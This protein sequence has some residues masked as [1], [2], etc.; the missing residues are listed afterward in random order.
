[1]RALI[2]AL[3]PES[4]EKDGLVT[5]LN[6]QIEAL[7]ARHGIAAQT[8]TSDEPEA[9]IEVKQVL[10]RIAQEA[11]HNTVKHSRARRVD[12][13]LEAYDSWLVLQ[14]TVDGVGFDTDESF[15]GHLGLRSM[16]E[17]ALEVGG[18]LEVESSRGQ[19]TRIVVRVPSERLWPPSGGRCL[20]NLLPRDGGRPP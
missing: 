2:F 6:R 9:P 8:I 20:P 1:M 3:R 12:V 17:R 10:H 4:L 18:S 16:R 5:A 15:P 7:R 13:H 14:I 19:G 11:V